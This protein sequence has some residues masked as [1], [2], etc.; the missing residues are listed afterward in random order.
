MRILVEM[1][2]KDLKLLDLVEK[3][4]SNLPRPIHPAGDRD[5]ADAAP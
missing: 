5:R 4:L 1:P 3:R 2:G